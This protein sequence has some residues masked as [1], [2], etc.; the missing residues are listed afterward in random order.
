MTDTFENAATP[1]APL[2]AIRA[3][4]VRALLAA[5]LF[6]ASAPL[7]KGLVQSVRPQMLA[8][9][10]YLGS[11]LG[12]CM[13]W[14][15]RRGRSSVE[16]PLTKRDLPW[17]AGAITA[18]GV[19]GPVLL[20]LGLAKTPA[21]SASLLL[22]MEGVFT[23]LLAWFV[24]RENF[25]RRIAVGMAAIV[26]GGALVSWQGRAELRSV[27]GPLAIAGACLCWALDNNLTQ[28]VSAGDPVQI[29]MLKG[30]IA[31]AVNTGLAFALGSHLPTVWRT[32]GAMSLGFVSYGL[33]L[34]L[35]VVALR[36]LG[37][38]RTGAYFSTAPFVGAALSIVIWRDPIT[39]SLVLGGTCMSLGVWLH[40]T[41]RHEHEHAHEPLEHE[42]LH[43]HDEHHQHTHGPTDPPITAP[44]EAHSHWHRHEPLVH[45]HA[46]A[47][48]IHHRHDH[49]KV[50]SGE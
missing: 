43:V 30:L 3:G 31:G 42:H 18:G 6:G 46:H 24:F 12:L 23:A 34:V 48:D 50:V 21:S 2:S 37:T 16:A 7:A 5:V 45:T 15:A 29:T 47:P 36:N 22:N 13:V 38:A 40:V 19:V 11:G 27:L 35:F 4:Q 1:K 32:V 10:L 8:G 39:L 26:L 33:S 44:D 49:E 14:L 17:L 28:K 25:D 20:M 41:E 9:L